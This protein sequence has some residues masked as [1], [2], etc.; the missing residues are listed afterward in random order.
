MVGAERIFNELQKKDNRNEDTNLKNVQDVLKSHH[1][2]KESDI[3]RY[4]KYFD[5]DVYN[6]KNY[7][8]HIQ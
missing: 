7:D 8:F 5:I 4:K 6:P 1:N 3:K 2:R